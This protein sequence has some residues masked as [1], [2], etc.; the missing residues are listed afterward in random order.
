M[1]ASSEE[2]EFVFARATSDQIQ[3]VLPAISETRGSQV[4]SAKFAH[5]HQT[6]CTTGLMT[7][8]T[9]ARAKK[10]MQRSFR[11]GRGQEFSCLLVLQRL[12]GLVGD[13]KGH[14]YWNPRSVWREHKVAGENL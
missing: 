8:A 10:E 7:S 6:L 5:S 3:L 9:N 4:R 13:M 14:R 2:I 12:S 11:C 1:N